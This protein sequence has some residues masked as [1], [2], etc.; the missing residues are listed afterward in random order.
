MTATLTVASSGCV[1]IGIDGRLRAREVAGRVQPPDEAQELRLVVRFSALDRVEVAH[2]RFRILGQAGDVERSE[3]EGWSA[4]ELERQRAANSARGRSPLRCARSWPPHTGSRRAWPAPAPWP[5]SIPVAGTAHRRAGPIRASALAI[6]S[7]PRGTSV[8]AAPVTSMFTAVMS[9]GSPVV[10]AS[11]MV[12]GVVRRS[13]V[14]STEAE[15][16]PSAAA[17]LRVSS[18]AS[19]ASRSRRSSVIA[20]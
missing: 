5:R 4:G 8:V 19:R 18:I 10:T 9:V 15:N 2:Q 7:V 6:A 17:A 12:V 14:T 3:A 13:M 20:A 11:V 16:Q 1:G